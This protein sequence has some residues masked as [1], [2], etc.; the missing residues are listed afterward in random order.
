MPSS[1]GSEVDPATVF[2]DLLP[3]L[4]AYDKG[5]AWACCPFHDDNHPS[6]CVNVE[7]GWYKCMS[8]S[9]GATGGSIVGFVGALLGYEYAEARRY[10]EENYG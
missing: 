9:C 8:S 2:S 1:R 6:L 5:F 7:T 4:Q 3:D 10:L